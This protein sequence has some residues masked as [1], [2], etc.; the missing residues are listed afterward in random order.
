MNSSFSLTALTYFILRTVKKLINCFR[1]IVYTG[2]FCRVERLYTLNMVILQGVVNS[3]CLS[4]AL[5]T[6]IFHF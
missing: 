2:R 5:K 3:T 1:P 4:R 6:K